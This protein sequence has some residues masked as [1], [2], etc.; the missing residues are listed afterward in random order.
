MKRLPFFTVLFLFLY[1]I[2]GKNTKT[3]R[4]MI[5]FRK[6]F[7]TPI[8]S[9]LDSIILLSNTTNSSDTLETRT[10]NPVLNF[11]FSDF[12][13]LVYDVLLTREVA[14]FSRAIDS[15]TNE[16]SR[17][18]L[19]DNTSFPVK[20][21]KVSLPSPLFFLEPVSDLI[22]WI[23]RSRKVST[24]TI[25]QY[26]PP[27]NLARISERIRRFPQPYRYV[28]MFLLIYN[29]YIADGR[30]VDAYIVD[31]GIQ[32]NNI[33]FSGHAMTIVDFTQNGFTDN[34][35][36]GTHVAGNYCFFP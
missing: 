3:E 24:H 32:S 15:V 11:S 25:T 7:G 33:D 12:G 8:S 22:F 14:G 26:N 18:I 36:H 34:Y 23:E 10:I 4:F 31:S 27:W 35:G 13:G 17:N 30:G 28:R 20:M 9:L 6:Q 5:L 1:I 2:D 29:R 21:P 19:I 16:F